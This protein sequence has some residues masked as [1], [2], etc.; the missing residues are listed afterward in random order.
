MKTLATSLLCLISFS[1][2]V[3][4]TNLEASLTPPLPESGIVVVEFNA[5]FN[6]ANSVDW[7][8]NVKDCKVKRVDILKDPELQLEHKIV[9]VPTVIVF[10]DGEEV[11]RFQANIMMQLDAD[12]EDVQQT[13][14]EL[15]FSDF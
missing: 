7:I 4:F 9:V 12:Q 15:I 6:S 11:K 13:V 2:G 1:T 8:D 14:D 5:A 10:N 3:I